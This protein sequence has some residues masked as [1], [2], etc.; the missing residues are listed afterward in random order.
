LHDLP[1][2]DG[3]GGGGG[4]GM[5]IDYGRIET[6]HIRLILA[7]GRKEPRYEGGDDDE[8]EPDDDAPAILVVYVSMWHSVGMDRREWTYP[9]AIVGTG[10]V[11]GAEGW[12]IALVLCGDGES[13]DTLKGA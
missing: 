6:A 13:Y 1:E 5:W 9:F 10:K 8:D 11:G 2:T 3:S 7:L 4:G 12:V